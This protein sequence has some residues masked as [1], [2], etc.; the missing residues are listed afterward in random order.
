VA[1]RGLRAAERKSGRDH[2]DVVI[3]LN[4]LYSFYGRA[5]MIARGQ[6]KTDRERD[7]AGVLSDQYEAQMRS[8]R[9]RAWAIL[10]K[11]FGADLPDGEN[12]AKSQV[13]KLMSGG[14]KR[15]E[16]LDLARRRLLAEEKLKG[17]DHPDI[18]WYLDLLAEASDTAASWEILAGSPLSGEKADSLKQ[19]TK[20]L[21]EQ[22]E[23]LYKRALEIVEKHYGPVHE[24]VARSLW[25]L[26]DHH[27]MPRIGK[28]AE[29]ESLYKRV[30]EV[31]KQL[32]GADS[33]KLLGVLGR[34]ADLYIEQNKYGQV[35]S[36]FKLAAA[37][38]DRHFEAKGPAMS[39][40]LSN[41][42]HDFERMG[43]KEEA[44]RLEER[45][46]MGKLGGAYYAR[47]GELEKAGRYL[48]ALAELG[49]AY[50]IVKKESYQASEE[51]R[52]LRSAMARILAKMPVTPRLPAKAKEHAI[53]ADVLLK[54][55]KF[56][57]AEKEF[58]S[59]IEI[60]PY[61]PQLHF[62]LALIHAAH[63][64]QDKLA[65]HYGFAIDSM[66]IY[67]E[68]AANADDAR[69]ANDKICQWGML[70]E[71]GK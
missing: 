14:E 32:Y 13:E 12:E 31:E 46:R 27:A 17:T 38:I 1:E 51:C 19:R 47:A 7:Q 2:P 61:I 36:I 8:A 67:L 37:I 48:A 39:R 53:R 24:N 11:H 30:L 52:E 57:D 66:Q 10:N 29:A 42:A 20:I 49:K 71:G 41:F 63:A 35:E 5:S 28:Y 4:A 70:K 65:V 9:E 50:G 15:A 56:F 68:L 40:Y 44:A 34:L 58:G 21:A 3:Y 62:N 43:R 69:A 60:A 23:S 26:A 16:A 55:G 25:S 18:V 64:E 54:A 59:A 22:A 45:A 33:D 6:W